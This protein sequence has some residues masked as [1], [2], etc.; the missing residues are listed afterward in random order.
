VL[1]KEGSVQSRILSW[2]LCDVTTGQILQRAEP[3]EEHN[4]Y[5]NEAVE[6]SSD[7]RYFLVGKSV[8]EA[9]TGKVISRIKEGVRFVPCTDWLVGANSLFDF[10]TGKQLRKLEAAGRGSIAVSPDGKSF[11][12]GNIQN[13]SSQIIDIATGKE[14]AR[15][16]ATTSIDRLAFSPD[17][18]LL[19]GAGFFCGA[20]TVWDMT[21]YD[22][23]AIAAIPPGFYG[24]HFVGDSNTLA[25]PERG[26]PLVDWRTGR[27]LERLADVNDVQ[28]LFRA[29]LSPDRKWYARWEPNDGKAWDPAKDSSIA[30]LD[31][32]TGVEIKR[33]KGHKG[34][35]G[36]IAFSRNGSRLACAGESENTIRVWDLRT[37]SEI[38]Q[39][40]EPE[41]VG[42]GQKHVSLSEDGRIMAVNEIRGNIIFVWN[43]D[44]KT[45]LARIEPPAS[46]F[47][48]VVVSPDGKWVA[49]GAGRQVHVVKAGG[50]SATGRTVTETSVQIWE[51]STG[52]EVH[53]LPG[54]SNIYPAEA[55]CG[56]SPD[57]RWLTTGDAM[58]RL[59]LWEV[60]T[61][62]EIHSF[63]GH[64]SHVSANFSPDARLLVAA[65]EEAPC[66]IW[67]VIGAG[68][69]AKPASMAELK[70]CWKELGEAD[71]KKA[72][73]AICRVAANPGPSVELVRNNLKPAT[74]VSPK[75]LLE[76]FRDLASDRFKERE[77]ATAEL[78]RLADQIEPAL[79][80]R[81]IS[82]DSADERA[83]L[84]S[85]LKTL[86][87][88]TPKRIHEGRALTALELIGTPEASKLL[89]DL[90]AGA[91]DDLL[92]QA[93]EASCIRLRKRSTK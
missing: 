71:A 80:K 85:I 22:Y 63:V 15:I 14:I 12:A 21:T 56:F 65:S 59:R 69:N 1:T 17:G 8:I 87:T 7:S 5:R 45:R 13:S 76:L 75:K 82:T 41:L 61:G 90:A 33:L 83:R 84:E 16:P 67:D 51:V 60:I 2:E 27:I 46:D 78:S 10:K 35:P 36:S 30:L 64:R 91:K 20:I 81:R 24:A 28:S 50:R 3:S 11:V 55:T 86:E 40:A 57:S 25:I 38:A 37:G 58:G 43:V 68:A 74:I 53:S 32:K 92:T 29:A 39:F 89:S 34:F 9:A 72:F 79:R 54:H 47:S 49:G 4:G 93:A 66:L 44:A 31:A 48:H 23:A 52:R 18:K 26:D 62:Q 77:A 6:F 70:A 19:A 42:R 73:R 88:P